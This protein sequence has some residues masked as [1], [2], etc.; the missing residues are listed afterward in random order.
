MKTYGGVDVSIH[1]LL[2]STLVG[3]EWSA[4]IPERF[5]LDQRGPGIH[6]IG[7]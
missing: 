3:A 2:T 4:S 5:T 7:G 6:W 1:V